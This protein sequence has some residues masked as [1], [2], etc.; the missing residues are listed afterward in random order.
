[1][2]GGVTTGDAH[3]VKIETLKARLLGGDQ[4]A[5][6]VLIAAEDSKETPARP[7]I[8]AFLVSLGSPDALVGTLVSEAR[9]R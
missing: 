6:A 4:A 3:K 1:M 9:G 2:L 7:V 8:D 5:A